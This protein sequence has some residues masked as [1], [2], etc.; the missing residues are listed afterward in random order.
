[1]AELGYLDDRAFARGLVARRSSARGAV[2]IAQE[3]A[4]KGVP[5]GVAEE[6]LS[7]LDREQQIAAAG[8]LA[9]REAAGTGERAAARLQRKGFS[10]S[11][12]REAL[13]AIADHDR[14]W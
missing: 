12:I 4:A 5:R 10:R 3:L 2:L 6:A 8:A 11:V 9:S 13:Q 7:V 1:M 14:D